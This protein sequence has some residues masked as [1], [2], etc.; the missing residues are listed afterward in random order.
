MVLKYVVKKRVFGFEETKT[1]M[2]GAQPLLVGIVTIA[3]CPQNK[4]GKQLIP[5]T[6]ASL[7]VFALR[8]DIKVDTLRN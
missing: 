1:K 7:V 2:Y 4:P 3:R 8:V 5:C 6:W